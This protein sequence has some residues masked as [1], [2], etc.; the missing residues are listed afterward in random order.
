MD[1]MKCSSATYTFI[2]LINYQYM[3][4]VQKQYLNSFIQ[5]NNS[6]KKNKSVYFD[7]HETRFAKNKK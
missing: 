3:K 4:E 5:S 2:S 1:N 6:I 7:N